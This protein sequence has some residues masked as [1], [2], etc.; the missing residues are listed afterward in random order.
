ME[1]EKIN[2]I[3]TLVEKQWEKKYPEGSLEDKRFLTEILLKYNLSDDDW[4]IVL[5]E[6]NRRTGI[7]EKKFWIS[8]Y[9]IDPILAF[10]SYVVMIYTFL[11]IFV[12]LIYLYSLP[13][14]IIFPNG[15]YAEKEGFVNG[16]SIVIVILGLFL[17]WNRMENKKN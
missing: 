7:L 8:K 4:N 14:K 17:F 1:K 5:S 15:T 16:L 10:L 2:E 9:L 3:A 6:C 13:S 12:G 11:Y